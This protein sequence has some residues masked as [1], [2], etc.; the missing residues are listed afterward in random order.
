LGGFTLTFDRHVGFPV[1]NALCKPLLHKT[2]IPLQLVD[3]DP[4]HLLLIMC[5]IN[6]VLMV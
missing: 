3:L 4:P 2:G 6:L 5:V 1:F